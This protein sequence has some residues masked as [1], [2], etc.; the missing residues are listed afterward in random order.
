MDVNRLEGAARH[1]STTLDSVLTNLS[2]TGRSRKQ[3][4]SML[5]DASLVLVSLWLAYSLRYGQPF[6]DFG[7]T[8]QLFLIVPPLT[9]TIFG[10]FGIYRWVVR[11]TNRRLF[12]QLAK[13]CVLSAVCLVLISFLLRPDLPTPRSLLVIYGLLL[14]VGTSGVRMVWQE[15]FDAGARGQ[16]VAI[17][18]AG[19]S[20]RQL[21]NLLA[22]GVE[23]RPV[24]FIDDNPELHGTMV[25][26]MPVLSGTSA[27]LGAALRR[28]EA[29]RLVLA[30]PS[31]SSIEYRQKLD[32]VS[33][34][35]LP[36]QTMPGIAELVSGAARVDE[37]RDVSVNDILG[38]AEVAPDYKVIGR[39]VTGQTVLVTGGGGSIGS[40]LCRQI[41]RLSPKH[42]I[43][44]DSCEA[45]LYHITEELQRNGKLA[46]TAHLGTVTD[47][48][49][50]QRLLAHH[51]VD[52]VYHA[53]AY[54]HVPIIE[55]QPAQG[56]ETNV[57]G[58]MTLLETAISLKVSDFVLIS[59]DKAVRPANAMGASKRV[60]EMILQAKAR[61]PSATCISMVRFGNVLGSSGSVV[62]KFKEQI[63][64]GGPVT[65]TDRE[66]T[67]YFMTIPEA[68]QLVLQSSAIAQGGDVFVLDMGEPVRIIDLATQMVHLYGKRLREDTNDPDDIEIIVEGLRPG[69]KM[70]EELFIDD[71]HRQTGIPKVFT[72]DEGF[73]AWQDLHA[74]L[75]LLSTLVEA[76]DK[77]PLR[78]ALMALAFAAQSTPMST[79]PS[80]SDKSPVVVAVA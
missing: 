40:E 38:R 73:L 36:I 50:M 9:V 30:M 63:M 10:A 31:L 34:L 55:A 29:D 42:L 64:A 39:K 13:G 72:A 56:V 18:G 48:S 14:L 33:G 71:S 1:F 66:I 6:A 16:P 12:R 80:P 51:E 28:V 41:A 27:D 69:E 52:T 60:A 26:G 54:K 65:V 46:F 8:W 22:E 70:Y 32:N 7:A 11:S 23:Y 5:A 44:L 17:Y 58:T 2:S 78:E 37:I 3:A 62:P 43:V 75:A 45:N 15:L 76:G 67:R 53:A 25:S 19:A 59:T 61:L 68:A 21:V 47:Q 20:G 35:G 79:E 77:E 24:A 57:F 49:A 4:V 74:R